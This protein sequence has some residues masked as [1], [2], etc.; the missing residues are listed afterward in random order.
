MHKR[1]ESEI[2]PSIIS[3]SKANAN[4]KTLKSIKEIRLEN[5]DHKIKNLNMHGSS[6]VRNLS[7]HHNLNNSTFFNGTQISAI[8]LMTN[9]SNFLTSNLKTHKHKIEEE[10]P[11]T[12]EEYGS[13][14]TNLY[15]KYRIT[16]VPEE[17]RTGKFEMLS[18]E[19]KNKIEK[20][21]KNRTRFKNELNESL[22][23]T[24]CYEGFPEEFYH[25]LDSLN[26]IKKNHEILHTINRNYDERHKQ[27]L[28]QK[29][30]EVNRLIDYKEKVPPKIKITNILQ[31]TSIDPLN[32]IAKEVRYSGIIP[33]PGAFGENSYVEFYGNYHYGNKN[34]PEGREQFTLS[35][36]LFDVLLFGGIVT[37]KS[38]CI[39]SL[40]P[41]IITYNN[42]KQV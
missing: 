38:Q 34:F 2:F 27:M 7:Q 33:I 41:C 17:Q 18:I 31:K 23:K 19:E 36:D 35:Y 4:N 32:N 40:D 10:K 13:K 30:T 9:T 11:E 29:L 22:T 39:W 6:S 5:L 20:D 12:F 28:F 24:T 16:S 15:K 1:S 42:F 21:L 26:I 14:I 8:S 25:P 3:H 37:N